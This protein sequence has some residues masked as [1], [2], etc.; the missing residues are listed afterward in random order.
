M[1]KLLA[2]VNR[3][4]ILPITPI[5][6]SAFEGSMMIHPCKQG[7][8]FTRMAVYLLERMES[9]LGTAGGPESGEGLLSPR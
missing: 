8:I 3:L 7:L 2:R 1:E 4:D 9:V 5:P 6:S